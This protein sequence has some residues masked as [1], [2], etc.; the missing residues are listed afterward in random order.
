MPGMSGNTTGRTKHIS[1][2]G[3]CEM[4]T[5][6]VD[7][8]E[9]EV[10]PTAFADSLPTRPARS[11]RQ[12]TWIGGRDHAFSRMLG[13]SSTS[14]EKT[15]SAPPIMRLIR[16]TIARCSGSYFALPDPTWMWQ[17][18]VLGGTG[19]CTCAKREQRIEKVATFTSRRFLAMVCLPAHGYHRV[20]A[21]LLLVVYIDKEDDVE[22]L[23]YIAPNRCNVEL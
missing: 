18:A 1:S 10:N 17:R 22:T 20:C 12:R 4:A 8:N 13:V 2:H 9:T 14:A 6:S 19:T 21:S 11:P 5:Y 7:G 23:R 3:T 16:H 15:V